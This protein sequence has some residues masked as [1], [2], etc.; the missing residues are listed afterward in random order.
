MLLQ[1]NKS[2]MS[3][4]D[5][6]KILKFER[7]IGEVG[8]VCYYKLCWTSAE[9][10]GTTG[11]FGSPM[12]FSILLTCLST[13][14]LKMRTS[15]VSECWHGCTRAQSAKYPSLGILLPFMGSTQDLF[16]FRV[17]Y[18]TLQ[19]NLPVPLRVLWDHSPAPLVPQYN[20]SYPP[21]PP[22]YLHS[23]LEFCSGHE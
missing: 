17:C 16:A 12:R 2:W 13:T 1:V 8:V 7:T 15:H 20:V 6:G 14:A 19:S 4:T 9:L 22:R 3:C 21:D 18:F 11:W 5:L 10:F 23:H